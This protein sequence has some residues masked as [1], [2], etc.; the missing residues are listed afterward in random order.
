MI[1]INENYCPQ[2]HPC[3]V[4]SICPVDAI[5]QKDAFSAPEIDY[6][7]CKDCGKCEKFCPVFRKV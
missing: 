3:P 4:I 6:S 7:K 1:E 5:I 2:N